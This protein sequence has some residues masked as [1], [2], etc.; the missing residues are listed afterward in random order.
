MSERIDLSAP[1]LFGNDAAE[2]EELDVFTAY[3]IDRPEVDSF[4]DPRR[5]I[6]IAR[7]YKGEGKSAL[8]RMVMNRLRTGVAPPLIVEARGKQLS[9][10]LQDSD[11]DP[12][13][14]EWKA[15]ILK[16]LA[17]KIGATIGMAWTD[18]AMSLVEEAEKGGFRSKSFVASAV[19]RLKSTAVPLESVKTE[20][21]EHQGLVKR[22]AERQDAMWL[23]VD[24]I[25]ENFRNTARNKAK[26]SSFFIA[27][28]ELVL[29]IPQLRL[30]LAVRPNTWVTISFEDEA[31]SKVNQY[32]VDLRW[33]ADEIRQVLLARIRG[34]VE[35]AAKGSRR[36]R[37]SGTPESLL[38]KVFETPVTW[39]GRS[40]GVSVPLTTLSRRRPRWL[41]ELCRE[42]AALAVARNRRK[43]AQQ[44][45][46][47]C[48]E[49]FGKRRIAD[50]VAEFRA[51]CS[52]IEDL[53]AGFAS[54][55]EV[56]PTNALMTTIDRRVLQGVYPKIHGVAGTPRPVDVAAFLFQ[57]GFLSAKR[58]L[59]DGEYEHLSYVDSPDLLKTRTNRDGGVTWEIHPVFRQALDLRDEAGR[60]LRRS[61]D[62]KRGR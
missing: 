61:P 36:F 15:S 33:S 13:V 12:W 38:N 54:Q 46:F 17:G 24:D 6:C 23:M 2:D 29:S 42:A 21:R 59:P 48:L 25:D 55:A 26:I 18:D 19:D 5:P 52:E 50:T 37:G 40:T 8:L 58:K 44:D 47:E 41:V 20:A 39:N 62:D 45:I 10:N 51:Q 30:R 28:R 56:Y 60:R 43:I 49:S 57:V 34:Y 27:A 7:A 9:P 31:L 1:D 16:L 22:W 14:R 3:A 11:T 32:C 4:L 53:I 35:R